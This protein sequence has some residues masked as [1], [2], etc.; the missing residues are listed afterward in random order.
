M[1]LAAVGVLALVGCGDDGD[2]AADDEG[3]G[4]DA[5]CEARAELDS[6]FA[7]LGEID[8][9]NDGTDALSA[10]VDDIGDDVESLREAA[11]DEAGDEADAVGEAYDALAAAVGD[12]GDGAIGDGAAAVGTALADFGTALGELAV[13][14]AQ[15]CD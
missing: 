15:D 7:S 1:A 5:V 9:V 4:E 8:I 3:S 12:L 6:S 14:L 10:A 11:G 13:A 2:D